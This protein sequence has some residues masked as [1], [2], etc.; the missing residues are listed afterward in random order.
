MQRLYT[1]DDVRGFA[2]RGC[3]AGLFPAPLHLRFIVYF[4]VVSKTEIEMPVSV[5]VFLSQLYNHIR[6]DFK[7][8]GIQHFPIDSVCCIIPNKCVD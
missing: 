4:T 3:V 2:V 6:H 5:T 1:F 7:F 8:L